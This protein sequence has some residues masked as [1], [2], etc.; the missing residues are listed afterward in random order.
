MTPFELLPT[1]EPRTVEP[2]PQS[3]YENVSKHLIKDVIRIM[4]NGIPIDLTKVRELET[5]V[6]TSLQH[7]EATLASNPYIKQ[8]LASRRSKG[9][10]SLK[11]EMQGKMKT[12]TE[13]IKPFDPSKLLHRSYYIKEV[14]GVVETGS[15]VA[16]GVPKW[17]VKDVKTYQSVNTCD[18]TSLLEKQPDASIASNAMESLAKDTA[19]IRNKAYIAKLRHTEAFV[20]IERFNASSPDQKHELLTG[21]LGLTSDKETDAW[22]KYQKLY[23]K[24]WKKG[25]DVSEIPIPKNQYSWNRDNVEKQLKITSDEDLRPLLQALVDHSFSA[26]IKN[27]FIK[28]FYEYT[29][30]GTLYGSLNLFGAKSFRLTSQNP[31]LLNMPS[32]GSIYAKPV[33]KCFVAPKGWVIVTA[34]YGAL[35]K[36]Y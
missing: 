16:P 30:D 32:T 10:E 18:F 31:N 28:S 21:L 29:I 19:F 13:F 5:T 1:Q 33:K 4:H 24:H 8:Y 17:S 7:V 27:N 25:Y 14:I 9:K 3:F 22:I 35:I 34:D 26:I 2:P 23:D 20:P 6:D 12:F 11:E 36:P 15:F